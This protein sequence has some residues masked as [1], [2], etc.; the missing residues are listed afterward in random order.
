MRAYVSDRERK[1][2]G[3]RERER[4]DF[5]REKGRKKGLG[6]GSGWGF[7]QIWGRDKTGIFGI[8]FFLALVSGEYFHYF[9]GTTHRQTTLFTFFSH[10]LYKCFW[11]I[12]IFLGVLKEG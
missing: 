10:F 2:G 9:F 1:R 12:F 7:G 8:I 4:V 3:R 6:F 5:V 11:F